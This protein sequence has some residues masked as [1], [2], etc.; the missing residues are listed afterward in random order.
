MT[1]AALRARVPPPVKRMLNGGANLLDP[2]LIRRLRAEEARPIPGRVLRARVGEPNAR[3]FLESGKRVAR[4]LETILADAGRPIGSFDSIWDFGA[5]SGRVL[6]QLDVAD[7]A[8]LQATD[9]DDEA[10]AWLADAHSR[11]RATAGDPLPPTPFPDAAFDLVYS[12]SVFTHISPTS[13]DLWLSEIARVLRP[14]GMAVLTVMGPGLLQRY[15]E[16]GRPGMTGSQH[17]QLLGA[18]LES[19]GIVF[20]PEPPTRWNRWRYRRTESNYGLTFHSDSYVREHW[21]GRLRVDAIAGE[22]INWQQ[23]AVICSPPAG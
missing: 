17:Q 9:V 18:D 1:N 20:A 19:E 22:S 10:C 11:V 21:A 7:S 14:G 16:G 15:R 6:T 5:G 23:S 8:E 4:E 12:I 2:L 3:A 13:Q